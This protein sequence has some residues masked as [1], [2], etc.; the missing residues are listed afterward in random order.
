MRKV[1]MREELDDLIATM[2]RQRDAHIQES[3]AARDAKTKEF[4]LTLARLRTLRA[5]MH[6]RS[7]IRRAP[8]ASAAITPPVRASIKAMTATHPDL[9]MTQIAHM[10]ELNSEGRVSEIVHGKRR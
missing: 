1:D 9:T 10:H 6:N 8:S 5:E 3:N 2:V 4:N 7:P